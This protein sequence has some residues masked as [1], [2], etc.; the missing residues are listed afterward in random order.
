MGGSPQQPLC[1]ALQ[2][3]VVTRDWRTSQQDL[4][5]HC[6]ATTASLYCDIL[7]QSFKGSSSTPVAK[8]LQLPWQPKKATLRVNTIFLNRD[9][10]QWTRR[11]I[12][13]GGRGRRKREKE[14]DAAK[15]Q[16]ERGVMS[17]R[18]TSVSPLASRIST[19]QRLK[20]GAQTQKN[21]EVQKKTRCNGVTAF[22]TSTHPA[23]RRIDG[24]TVQRFDCSC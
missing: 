8:D 2:Q 6:P 10:S 21:I 23:Q 9:P 11:E 1:A 13:G 16:H 19:E 12:G 14:M 15:T 7:R 3:A 22:E 5:R 24:K 17:A 20:Y 4:C 18:D